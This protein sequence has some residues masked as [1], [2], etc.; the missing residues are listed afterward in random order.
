MCELNRRLFAL[1]RSG[2][3]DTRRRVF[4]SALPNLPPSGVAPTL[5]NVLA[6]ATAARARLRK[7][8]D[9]LL[10]P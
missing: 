7:A 2:R 4:E 1:P 9:T 5:T 10:D 3:T 6:N 8:M